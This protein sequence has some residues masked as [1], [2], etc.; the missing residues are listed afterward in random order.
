LTTAAGVSTRVFRTVSARC[1]V[2]APNHPQLFRSSHENAAGEVTLSHDI[3]ITYGSLSMLKTMS[4]ENVDKG[5]VESV[6]VKLFNNSGQQVALSQPSEVGAQSR[7][8]ASSTLPSG[9]YHLVLE[10]INGTILE[11]MRIPLAR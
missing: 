1:E 3:S 8:L 5:T 10:D 4:F 6:I 2:Q 9:I 11:T 7:I